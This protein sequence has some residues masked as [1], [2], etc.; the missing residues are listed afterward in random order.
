M[1]IYIILSFGEMMRMLINKP[2]ELQV[3]EKYRRM[4]IAHGIQLSW[5][6]QMEWKSMIITI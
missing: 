4:L 2:D 6:I 1:V 5:W 3:P